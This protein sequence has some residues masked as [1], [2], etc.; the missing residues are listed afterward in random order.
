MIRYGTGTTEPDTG[1]YLVKYWPFMYEY[2]RKIRHFRAF[3]IIGIT[4][5]YYIF[6]VRVPHCYNWY[7]VLL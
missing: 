3:Y 5:D 6:I 1:T 2:L 4:K 7:Y